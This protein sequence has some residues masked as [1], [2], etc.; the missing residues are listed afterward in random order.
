[1]ER[2]EETKKRLGRSPDN[3][4]AFNL[5]FLPAPRDVMR[6]VEVERDPYRAEARRM[7]FGGR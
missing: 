3:V 4:D 5:A 6:A 7:L 1:V 2:K